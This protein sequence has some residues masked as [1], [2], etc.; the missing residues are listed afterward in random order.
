MHLFFDFTLTTLCRGSELVIDC[1]FLKFR[2]D[3]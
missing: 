2:I 3:S 1:V